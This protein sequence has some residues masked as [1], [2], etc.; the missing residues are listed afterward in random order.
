MGLPGRDR[1]L[2]NRQRRR[3]AVDQLSA[4]QWIAVTVTV[5]FPLTITITFSLTITITVV[6]TFTVGVPVAFTFTAGGHCV[7]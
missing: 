2:A 1:D 6:I 4:H 7:C 3:S 5:A